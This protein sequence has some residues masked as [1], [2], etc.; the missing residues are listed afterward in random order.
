MSQT[1]A[2]IKPDAT[3]AGHAGRI[4]AHLESSGFA[5][6]ALRMTTLTQLQ[7]RSFYEVHRERP[8]YPS[9]VAFMTSGPCIPI[10]LEAEDA[11]ARLRQAI[12]AT[13]PAQAAEGTVRRLYAES[14]ERNAIHGSDSNE[15]A[16]REI[17]FFFSGS[18]VLE[19]SR[20]R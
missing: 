10:V 6:R 11:V 1:L 9:L 7:A 13:D 8:F 5:V 16:R 17:G 15:N 12:G 19:R 3:A 4:I 14:V 20:P 2:I 18:D